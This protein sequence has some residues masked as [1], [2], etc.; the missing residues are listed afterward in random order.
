[1]DELYQKNILRHAAR[2]SRSGHL[3]TP[4]GTATLQ[5]PLCGD[6]ITMELS[7]KDGHIADIAHTMRACVLCQASASIIAD[8]AKGK[9]AAEIAAVRLNLTG[10]LNGQATPDWP[11]D[12]S[13]LEVFTPVANHPTRHTCVTLPFDA[14]EKAF[15][16]AANN[17]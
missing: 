4:G 11:A 8:H 15:E 17:S 1:L 16:A 3:Q 7:L 6:R 5:S 14:L 13:E 2:A 9:T 12:W 10:L